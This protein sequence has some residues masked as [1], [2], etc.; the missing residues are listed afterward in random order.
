MTGV[1]HEC[2]FPAAAPGKPRVT[3]SYIDSTKSSREIDEEVSARLRAGLQLYGIDEDRMIADP[4]DVIVTQDLCPVCAVSPSDFR[5]HMEAAGCTARV[6]TLNPS[7]L[8]DVI[9]CVVTVGEALG[10][11]REAVA[12]AASLRA[13]LDAV[14]CAVERAPRKRV[15]TIEW[16]KPL[17]PGGHWVPEM[18]R[19]AGGEGG[20]IAPGEPS[21][22]VDW[23]ELR[24]EAADVI[25]LMPCG[26]DP[27]R[28]DHEARLL[29]R[30]NGWA[31]QAAVRASEVYCVDGNA[32]YSRPGPRLVDGTEELARI[33]HPDRWTT[34]AQEGAIR[35]LS[36]VRD[37]IPSFA[38]YR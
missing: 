24:R 7:T 30:L 31:E 25:V 21:R 12:L 2:D 11:G 14:R 33:L 28:A 23:E 5:G 13:R 17:M 1:T 3:V 38:P 26:F 22:K 16:I 15:L 9:A 4:P 29:W 34:P 20:P 36:D 10:R 19:I 8:D 18:V 6:V 27:E 32:R 35:R 37:G